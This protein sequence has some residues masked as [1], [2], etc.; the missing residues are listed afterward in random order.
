[1]G[2]D[3]AAFA[4]AGAR[5]D[6]SLC[7]LRVDTG[8]LWHHPRRKARLEDSPSPVYG[9][10]LL[11]RFGGNTIRGSNPRSSAASDLGFL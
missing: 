9:A 6:P 3:R 1:M 8:T 5:S 4:G 10:A 2:K 7:R 11:M